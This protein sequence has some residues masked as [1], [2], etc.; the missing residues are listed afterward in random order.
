MDAL[1]SNAEKP[2]F[3]PGMLR[4]EKWVSFAEQDVMSTMWEGFWVL[5]LPVHNRE[6]GPP[7]GVDDL[8]GY[9]SCTQPY[10]SPI[11]AGVK[12]TSKN[13]GYGCT[14]ERCREARVSAQ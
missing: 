13:V 5:S 14:A 7:M 1:Q 10:H 9:M 3:Q 6:C 11:T 4:R 2:W 8:L 12:W